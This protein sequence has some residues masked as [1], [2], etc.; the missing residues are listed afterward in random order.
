VANTLN[1]IHL[2]IPGIKVLGKTVFPGFDWRPPWHIPTLDQGGITTRPTLAMLSANSRPEAVIPLSR[3]GQEVRIIINVPPT[4][5][6]A[7]TGRAVAGSLRAFF[8]A[9]G[10]LEIP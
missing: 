6:P 9:G 7:E 3:L 8:S 10:R 1:A 4:A 5:N 2:S